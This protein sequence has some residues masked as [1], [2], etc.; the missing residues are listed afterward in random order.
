MVKLSEE[1]AALREEMEQL[2]E[3]HKKSEAEAE[4]LSLLSRSLQ[5]RWQNSSSRIRAQAHGAGLVQSAKRLR[6][7][8][9]EE[10]GAEAREGSV[11]CKR[12]VK[13]IRKHMGV[14]MGRVY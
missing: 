5:V 14:R 3:E 1:H 4:R 2:R 8:S 7:L 6:P 11:Q 13:I 10:R 9:Q 12:W